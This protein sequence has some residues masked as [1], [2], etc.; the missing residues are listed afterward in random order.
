MPED[1]P[2]FSI[3]DDYDPDGGRPSADTES[4]GSVSD[5]LEDKRLGAVG[6]TGFSLEEFKT[7]I[8]GLKQRR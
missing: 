3:A 4:G 7:Y 5:Y 6:D 2:N 1:T 8:S